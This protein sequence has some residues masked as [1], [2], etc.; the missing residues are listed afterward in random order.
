MA[1]DP[2]VG[3]PRISLLRCQRIDAHPLGS[4]FRSR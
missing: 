1:E 4:G 3:A 2:T